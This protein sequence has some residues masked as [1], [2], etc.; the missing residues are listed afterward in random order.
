LPE[1]LA[2]RPATAAP[3]RGAAGA[4]ALAADRDAV[5]PGQPLRLGLRLR[6]DPHWHTY[7]RNP[8]DSGL[9]TQFDPSLPEG[10]RAGPIEWPAPSRILI[11]PLANYGYEGEIVLPRRLEVPAHVE[12]D[13][14]TFRV[15]ASWLVCRDVC[16][17][18]EANLELVLPV[19]R[20]GSAGP[21]PYRTLFDRA[22]A[23]APGPAVAT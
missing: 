18:G 15:A 14:V 4:A 6:H 7:W 19:A 11:P 21:G 16:I 17:P 1:P 9:P 23:R 5:A 8:G 2:T 20:D 22:A 3:V 12:A 13:S 10:F